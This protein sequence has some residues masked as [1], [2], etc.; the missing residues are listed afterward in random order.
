MPPQALAA[1]AGLAALARAAGA[2][3]IAAQDPRVRWQGRTEL[4]AD[5]TSVRFDWPA[6]AAYLTLNNSGSLTLNVSSQTSALNRVITHVIVAGEAYEQTRA[7]VMPGDNAILA[8][9]NIFGETSLRVFFELEPSFNGAAADAGYVVQGFTLDAGDALQQAPR[10]RAIEVIGDSISAGYGA[11]GAGGGCPVMDYT[12]GNFGTYN[13][14][15]CDHFDAECTVIAWSGKGLLENCCDSGERMVDYYLQTRG[16]TSFTT[17]W[18]FSRWTPDAIIINLGCVATPQLDLKH[19]PLSTAPSPLPS[20]P[21]TPHPST[22]LAPSSTTPP[23]QDQR[24]RARH[25]PRMGGE[26]VYNGPTVIRDHPP[27]PE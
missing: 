4:L 2:V 16:G 18:D 19:P 3:F 13:R 21:S 22:P 14:Q 26:R 1:I 11:S 8:V 24:L 17:D 15:I 10:K 5:N 27:T 9:Q 6:V 20:T 25:W 12:S 7:W 23:S